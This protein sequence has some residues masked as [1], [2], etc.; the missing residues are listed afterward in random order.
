MLRTG[1]F[2]AKKPV[3][4]WPQPLPSPFFPSFL[5]LLLGAFR[6]Q[7]APLTRD[8]RGPTGGLEGRA[9]LMR[10]GLGGWALGNRGLEETG[11]RGPAS[12]CTAG[13]PRQGAP[14]PSGLAPLEWGVC[15][16]ACV[17]ACENKTG[18]RGRE[19]PRSGNTR[20]QES[21]VLPPSRVRERASC[22][23]PRHCVYRDRRSLERRGR[24]HRGHPGPRAPASQW[25]SLVVLP[26]GQSLL[27]C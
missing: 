13:G 15:A 26:Q 17:S 10:G 8:T 9:R 7:L 18:P 27:D 23:D 4:P 12:S 24:R 19:R 25:P 16:C 14:V 22:R 1:P 11:G 6:P 20:R 5:K 2:S 21:G 3:L